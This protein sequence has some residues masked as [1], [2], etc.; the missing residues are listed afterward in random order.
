MIIITCF[1]SEVSYVL[2]ENVNGTC[3][4]G[5]VVLGGRI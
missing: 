2:S 4:A 5:I 3:C 1:Q